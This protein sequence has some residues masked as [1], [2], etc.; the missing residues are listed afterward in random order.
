MAAVDGDV[1]IGD[2]RSALAVAAEAECLELA[3]DFEGERV[4]E[5]QHVDVITAQ[6]GV[7]ECALGCAPAHYT[8]HVIAAPPGEVVRRW[9]LVGGAVKVRA[10]AQDVD[11][12]A[13]DVD[14]VEVGHDERAPAFGR[15]RA[16]QEMERVGDGA[17][18]GDVLGRERAPLVVDGLGVARTV[19][20]DGR[21]DE[22]EL[23]ARGAVDVHVAPG[24]EREFGGGEHAPGRDELV[25]G[26]GPRRG[27]LVVAVFAGLRRDQHHH[28]GHA[29]LDRG[30]RL[31][32]HADP[33]GQALPGRADP[34]VVDQRGRLRARADAVDVVEGQ[35]G[36]VERAQDRLDRQAARRFAVQPTSLPGVVH[37]D[38]RRGAPR[39][40]HRCSIPVTAIQ[41]SSA[42]TPR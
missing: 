22:R 14:G 4:V 6:P 12:L 34:Q 32:D 19:V 1:A 23:F 26:P 36:I 7:A 8:V 18:R 15:G 33:E 13:L 9:V 31:G 20:A 27:G 29:V 21:G 16:V 40:A 42:T 17:R 28:V 39:R 10:A 2:E 11:G 30:D 37:P 38:D 35:P 41:F 25:F 24:D 3:D 5:F